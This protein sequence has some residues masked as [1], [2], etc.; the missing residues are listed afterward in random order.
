MQHCYICGT[1]IPGD[2]Y[3]RVVKTGSSGRTYYGRR[4]SF[5]R[6]RSEG[7]R[8]VCQNCAE[9]ID[10][11]RR[12]EGWMAGIFVLFIVGVLVYGGNKSNN[13]DTSTSTVSTVVTASN[14][15]KN[16][17]TVATQLETSPDHSINGEETFVVSYGYDAL[18]YNLDLPNMP[19]RT[20][21][22]SACQ[23]ACS[24][25]DKCR[26]YVF[27]KHLR[28][29]FLKIDT[30]LIIRNESAYLGYKNDNSG[31]LSISSIAT[32]DA[33]GMIGKALR[34]HQN[35][36]WSECVLDCDS[37]QSCVAFNYES[38]T[39]E[40]MELSIVSRRLSMPSMSSGIK[41]GVTN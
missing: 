33:T 38:R 39:R 24:Q 31:N 23:S 13:S 3:R 7:L 22:P 8:T 28:S 5:S 37:D 29:C 41:A 12:I 27:N 19:I 25:D 40:C 9:Q 18:G 17:S 36:R 2:G 26:A 10:R 35:V 20:I 14:S 30:G 21:S 1:S 15:T 11:Q 32:F 6:S 16:D 34:S 4:I